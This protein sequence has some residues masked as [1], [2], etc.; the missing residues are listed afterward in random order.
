MQNATFQQVSDKDE[1]E[2]VQ[3]ST[4]IQNEP[5][6]GTRI[7]VVTNQTNTSTK[8]HVIMY[9]QFTIVFYNSVLK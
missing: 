3:G 7:R 2:A 6:A 4:A 9:K 5:V 8:L 1:I